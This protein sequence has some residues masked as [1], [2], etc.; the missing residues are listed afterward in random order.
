MPNDKVKNVKVSE[1]TRKPTKAERDADKA[2]RMADS[3]A[4]VLIGDPVLLADGR[5]AIAHPTTGVVIFPDRQTLD[6][7]G[8]I[9]SSDDGDKAWLQKYFEGLGVEFHAELPLEFRPSGGQQER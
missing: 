1:V 4:K 6:E 8:A 5:Y 9:P 3:D 2:A 7:I